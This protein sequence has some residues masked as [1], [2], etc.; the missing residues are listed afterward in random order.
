MVV[1]DLIKGDG[2]LQELQQT[3]LIIENQQNQ[4]AFYQQIDTLKDFKINNLSQI[5]I[6]KDEQFELE[7]E[8]SKSLQKELKQKN[9]QN[10]FLKIGIGA[11]ILTILAN[12]V[13]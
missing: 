11:S 2:A 8:K 12:L 1:K 10:T 4:L 5:I 3:Y 7:R 13:K 6:R 9:T